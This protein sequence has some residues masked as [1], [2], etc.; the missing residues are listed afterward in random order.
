ME[1]HKIAKLLCKTKDTVNRTNWQPT[2]WEKILINP[3]PDRGL[4]SSIYKELKKLD[5][6]DPNN[7][8]KEWGNQVKSSQLRNINW[9]IST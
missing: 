6:R 1:P 2:D 5:S 4:I 9:P 3:T 7:P 8:T